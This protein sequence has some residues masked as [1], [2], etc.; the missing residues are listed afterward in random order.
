MYKQHVDGSLVRL[1]LN[2][3]FCKAMHLSSRFMT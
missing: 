2:I 1:R 3:H